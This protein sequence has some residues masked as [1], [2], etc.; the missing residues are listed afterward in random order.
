MSNL[1]FPR[2]IYID[3]DIYIFIYIYISLVR[4]F[5]NWLTFSRGF[6]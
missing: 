4:D 2:Y 5:S 6:L 1:E 3:I